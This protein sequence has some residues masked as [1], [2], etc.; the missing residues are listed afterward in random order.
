MNNMKLVEWMEAKR[1]EACR[2]ADRQKW[3]KLGFDLPKKIVDHK[4]RFNALF[5]DRKTA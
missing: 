4:A 3:I 5:M 2:I 1:H